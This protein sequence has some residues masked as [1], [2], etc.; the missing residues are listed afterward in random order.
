M[1]RSFSRTGVPKNIVGGAQRFQM[2]K[3][4]LSDKI[5][6]GHSIVDPALTGVG[7]FV[8]SNALFATALF[9]VGM[10][11]TILGIPAGLY[12][13][14]QASR[15][16]KAINQ[17]RLAI[18]HYVN[19]YA[20][21]MA[22]YAAQPGYVPKVT[23]SL[24]SM[25]KFE[26]AA[27]S[28]ANR[29]LN[30]L[31]EKKGRAALNQLKAN[32]RTAGG[33]ETALR[34][35]VRDR[36]AQNIPLDVRK[37]LWPQTPAPG[38]VAPVTKTPA[39]PSVRAGRAILKPTPQRKAG[40]GGARTTRLGGARTIH[41]GA[42][43]GSFNQT[44]YR[45][46]RGDTLYGLARQFNYADKRRFVSDFLKLNPGVNNPNRIFAGQT[47]KMPV[48]GPIKRL[49]FGAGS[50]VQAGKIAGAGAVS[51]TTFKVQRGDTLWGLASKFGY[52]NKRRFIGEFMKLN[53]TV[54]D[55]NRII[56][57]HRY[58]APKPMVPSANPIGP[59]PQQGS[60]AWIGQ[61]LGR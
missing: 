52:Q 46:V 23:T 9:G 20:Q 1:S 6:K 53:P 41:G 43:T 55:P 54:S 40:L 27:I 37:L 50:T 29:A 32:Y 58:I 59:K 36:V 44:N 24:V 16:G 15:E 12:Q 31:G 61:G 8:G 13:I 56:A 4:S 33:I 49:E 47:Y 30:V 57:G 34:R 28:D 22:G 3:G 17:T 48:H 19:K 26:R 35:P 60:L 45:M 38:V 39:G 5:V 11:S 10:G 51:G 18:G 7:L 21:T 42:A 14:G 2:R 25:Q